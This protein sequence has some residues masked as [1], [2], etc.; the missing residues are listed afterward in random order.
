MNKSN[1][2]IKVLSAGLVALASLTMVILAIINLVRDKGGV[3]ETIAFRVIVCV[4][5]IVAAILSTCL[6]IAKDPHHF[7]SK[8][9]VYNGLLLGAGIFVVLPQ[10]GAFADVIVG[11]LIPCLII[12]LG[13]F[14]MIATVISLVNKINKR[15]T[16]ILA[17]I[18]GVLMLVA[19]VLLLCFAEKAY[20]VMWL[21]IGV[22]LLV[23]SIFA[24]IAALKKDKNVVNEDPKEIN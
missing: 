14:I 21:V 19:G 11:W 20:R 18:I 24:L 1:K 12:G 2:I 22:L 17:M 10:A 15:N 9:V 8:L 16:D 13:V 23:S 4:M 6:V 3:S 7:D 5:L